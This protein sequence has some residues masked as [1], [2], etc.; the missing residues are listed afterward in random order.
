MRVG[1][2]GSLTRQKGLDILQSLIDTAQDLEFHMFSKETAALRPSPAL[3]S[4]RYLKPTEVLETMLEMDAFLLTVVPQGKND[5][6]SKYT[7]PLK[8]YEYLAAGRPILV[9]DLPVLREDVDE[10]IV[11][12][13]KNSVYDFARALADIRS[14]RDGARTKALRGLSLAKER[15]WSLRAKRIIEACGIK[16]HT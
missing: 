7:S 4:Y 2:F 1:Y 15:T 6:I 5:R 14:N 11:F 16:L 3:K 8:L 10:R 13:C 9:S 12:F